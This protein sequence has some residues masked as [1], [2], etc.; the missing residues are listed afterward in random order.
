MK[1]ILLKLSGELLGNNDGKGLSLTSIEKIA[2]H[3]SKIKTKEEIQV[4]IVIGGGNILRGK[5][6]SGT[7]FNNAVADSMGMIG[8]VINGLALQEALEKIGTPAKLMTSIRMEPTA[9]FYAR[10]NAINYLES[11]NVVIFA[12]GTGNPFFT[13]DSAAV[14]RACETDCDLILKATHVDG[15]Y[16]KDPKKYGEKA[17]FYKEITYKEA[18]EKDLRIMDNTAFALAWREGKQIV[19]FNEKNLSKISDI[20][21]GKKI[22]TLVK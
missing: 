22:G 4:A 10:K 7:N 5:E 16:D 13:T 21:E 6:F 20:L 3:I 8:T 11:G 17:N 19:V 1:R 14:L 9:E 18:L 2:G 15:I 12:G